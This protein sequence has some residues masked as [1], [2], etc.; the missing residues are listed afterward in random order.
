MT[1]ETDMPVSRIFFLTQ[2]HDVLPIPHQC[3]VQLVRGETTLPQYAGKTM[4]VADWYVEEQGA[5]QPAMVVNETYSIL[6]FDDS[7]KI[8]W[9]RCCPSG[10]SEGE[11]Q[12]WSPLAQEKAQL[13]MLASEGGTD[14]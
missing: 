5:G 8:D 11:G 2:T 7:G 10:Q 3:Y 12:I 1:K 4:R 6:V 14:D 13:Q 9:S